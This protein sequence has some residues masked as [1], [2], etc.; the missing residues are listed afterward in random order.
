MSDPNTKI[1]E[2]W[3]KEKLPSDHYL[4]QDIFKRMFGVYQHMKISPEHRVDI[5]FFF[6]FVNSPDNPSRLTLS[7]NIYSRIFIGVM[8]KSILDSLTAEFEGLL[9]SE[10]GHKALDKKVREVVAEYVSNNEQKECLS[11]NNRNRKDA[12]FCDKCGKEL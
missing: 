7:S 2:D 3:F 12:G 10:I 4:Q 11:C 8:A 9:S 6:S 5:P 1:L